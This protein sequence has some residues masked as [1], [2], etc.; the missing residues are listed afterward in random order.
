MASRRAVGAAAAAVPLLLVLLLRVALGCGA[1]PFDEP[2]LVSPAERSSM[3]LKFW[4]EF[5]EVGDG[6]SPGSLRLPPGARGFGI[7]RGIDLR[8]GGRPPRTC[9]ASAVVPPLRPEP[10]LSGKLRGFSAL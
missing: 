6:G 2:G 5:G 9:G 4:A 10:S 1:R 7:P 3:L 8:G